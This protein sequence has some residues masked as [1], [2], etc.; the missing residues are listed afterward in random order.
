[1][2][3]KKEYLLAKK[4]RKKIYAEIV[5][6]INE[7]RKIRQK[8]DCELYQLE[9]E[10]KYLNYYI[11]DYNLVMNIILR[12]ANHY[13]HNYD[14]KKVIA[15]DFVK[16]S[17]DETE[18]IYG[19]TLII[20]N[21]EILD[22]IDDTKMYYYDELSNIVSRIVKNG[23]SVVIIA[24]NC[25]DGK[26]KPKDHF[27]KSVKKDLINS[28]IMGNISCFLH[29]DELRKAVDRISEYIDIN[30]PDFQNISEDMLYDL[31]IND[32]Q[33]IIVKQKKAN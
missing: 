6:N 24:P 11:N 25:F 14:M 23:N 3:L 19:K 12:L 21:N 32:E 18:Q 20:A 2:D 26:V 1:M 33:Q 30:G 22:D 28:G 16:I 13:G 10:M 15:T 27:C 31:I 29:D 4:N 8:C 9:N 17:D 5:E 7:L